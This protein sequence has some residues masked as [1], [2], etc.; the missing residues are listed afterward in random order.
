MCSSLKKVTEVFLEFSIIL[1]LYVMGQKKANKGF[2]FF[3]DLLRKE[4]GPLNLVK[5][6]K[7]LSNGLCSFMAYEASVLRFSS[8]EEMEWYLICFFVC[9]PLWVNEMVEGRTLCCRLNGH[10]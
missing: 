3:R 10:G 6:L 4:N 8:G 7:H 2:Q 9:I 5:T 1:A